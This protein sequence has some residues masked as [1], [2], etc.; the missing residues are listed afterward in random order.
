[1]FCKYLV[2][3]EKAISDTENGVR[4]GRPFEIYGLEQTIV[5]SISRVILE[6]GSSY[7][8]SCA[9][10]QTYGSGSAI[11]ILAIASS[12]RCICRKMWEVRQ[13]YESEVGRSMP[14]S[15]RNLQLDSHPALH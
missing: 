4:F 10:Y 8:R 3:D 1:M 15:I 13:H 12:I 6:S 11:S 9:E 2:H 5:F 7:D 14:V